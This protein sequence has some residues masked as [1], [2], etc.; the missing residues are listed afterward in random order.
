MLASPVVV[1]FVGSHLKLVPTI[2]ETVATLLLKFDTKLVPVEFMHVLCRVPVCK[3][4]HVGS[5]V[6]AFNTILPAFSVAVV[7]V[8]DGN[9]KIVASDVLVRAVSAL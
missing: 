4:L 2:F 6:D 9:T 7:T 5:N 1:E 8:V 3:T